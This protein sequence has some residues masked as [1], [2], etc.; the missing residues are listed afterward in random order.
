LVERQRV[1]CIVVRKSERSRNC[2]VEVVAVLRA[3]NPNP[4]ANRRNGSYDRTLILVYYSLVTNDI[5]D[6]T[7]KTIKTITN[8]PTTKLKTTKPFSNP[9]LKTN[10]KNQN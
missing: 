3:P 8:P 4:Y 7:A 5:I 1:P 10:T 6:K 2:S 9:V